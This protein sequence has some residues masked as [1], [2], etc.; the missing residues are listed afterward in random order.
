MKH[1]LYFYRIYLKYLSNKVWWLLLITI[2]VAFADG[3]GISMLLP[4]LQSL[5]VTGQEEA[6]N[7]LFQITQ[8]L[9]VSGSLTGI[10]A[11]MFVLFLGKAVLKFAAG[12]FQSAL[13]RDLFRYLK[14]NFYDAI[15]KVDYQY[16]TRRN[17]GYFIT[18]MN[19][20]TNKLVRSF[21]VFV[22][23]V[24]GTVMTLSYLTMAALISW[25]VSAMAVGLGSLILGLLTVVNRYV[26][27]LSQKISDEETKMSQIAIQALYA[28]KYI[29]ST[30]SYKPIQQQYGKS[31]KK[32][33]NLQFK[34]EIANAFTNSLQELFAI[35]LLIAMILI[36]VVVLGYPISAV[37]VVLLLFYRGVN[38]LMGIQKNWQQLIQN[39]G[40]VESVDTELERL[41]K[42][43]AKDGQLTALP[44]LNQGTLS[45][46]NLSFAYA[47]EEAPVL[48]QLNID[49]APNT[50][51]AFVGPSG[52]GKTT[53]VDLMTGLLRPQ[54]GD[55]QLDGQSLSE[56]QADTW[57]SKIGY[58]AQD[59]TVFDDTVAN[60]IALFR[61]EATPEAIE[62]A[63]RMA[64][65]HAFIS[66]LPQGYQTRIGDKGVRLSGGQKQRLFI[67]RELFK[68]PDLLILD[69]A[70]SALDSASERYIQ[71]SIDQLKGKITVII[72]A[73]R[74]STIKNADVIYVLD[75]GKVVESG[76]YEE[77][78]DNTSSRFSE[79]VELQSF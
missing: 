65:A 6:D 70:T 28:F 75:K 34:T 71:D 29:V 77:L 16:F 58:V 64:S 39:H 49:I 9:G 18:V 73:H 76:S 56:V 19:G 55:L 67:A 50:T 63:A 10:L 20:H 78:M 35:T 1:L 3:L 8:A 36:E 53:L 59:L 69:E 21:N 45:L 54:S 37:F 51:V 24:T 79:M 46:N 12:Y 74:L 47:E 60:N 42:H 33:T 43:R 57:R 17:A 23:L 52:A 22:T 5:E 13:F 72:I 30:A 15:L 68:Q 41:K 31:I 11:F 7:I 25:Q 40:F 32:L 44:P 48:Q 26:R 62:Q 27:K 61:E 4:L 2:F 66:E 14:I 38:Q